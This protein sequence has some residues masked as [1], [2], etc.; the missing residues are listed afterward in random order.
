MPDGP[1]TFD[2]IIAPL[3]RE[4]FLSESWNKSCLHLKGVKGRF[5][6]LLTWDELN[7]ILEWHNPPQPQGQKYCSLRLFQEGRLVDVRQYIDGPPGAMKLNAGGLIAGLSK[8][9]S[10]ILDQVQAIAPRVGALAE[11]LQ[12]IFQGLTVANLYAGW[13]KQKAFTLHWDPQEV[14]ILQLSGRKHWQV[15][16][17]TR[18]YPLGD[19]IEKGPMPTGQ[20]VFDGILEDGDMLYLPRG[21]WHMAHPLD[22][23]SLHLNFG[24]EPPNGADFL[25]WW[26]RKMLRHPEVRRNLPQGNDAFARRTYFTN[27]LKLME[28][29]PDRDPIGE[30]LREQGA[31]RRVRPR[32]RLPLAPLEQQ[33]PITMTTKFRLAVAH[34]LF[35]EF[36]AGDR[37]AR[38]KIAG[39]GYSFPP[40]LIPA[41]EKLSGFESVS[42]QALCA[43]IHDQQLIATLTR[44]LDT[45]AEDGAILKESP[46]PP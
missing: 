36:E 38:F 2:D 14:F 26:T 1:I 41:F 33:K 3:P 40:A 18:P 42:L 6:S 17:P 19:D 32:I 29:S 28:D 10:L 22:E 46:E 30:F 9:A 13:G 23:P 12:D 27:L 45:L 39:I 21:W 15:H 24:I 25:R 34:S 20:P 5:T 43:G 16:A 8:G 11:A 7:A 37:A 35:T 31:N 4:R 44:I